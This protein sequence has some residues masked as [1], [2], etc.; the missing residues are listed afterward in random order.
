MNNLGASWG[1]LYQKRECNI[2][3]MK[4]LRCGCDCRPRDVTQ[5][6]NPNGLV[7]NP[8]P[9]SF[10]VAFDG[11][12]IYTLAR[13]LTDVHEELGISFKELVTTQPGDR[14]LYNNPS[15]DGVFILNKGYVYLDSAPFLIDI[16]TKEAY[17]DHI[18]QCGD[19]DALMLL[20]IYVD[21]IN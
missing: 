8:R 16:E 17:P 9:Y 3:R 11:C 12:G 15:I 20:W 5:K 19:A 14:H 13:R 7:R 21:E 10:L 2:F 6:I 18:W 1:Q 4:F